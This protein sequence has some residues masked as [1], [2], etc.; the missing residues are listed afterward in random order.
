MDWLWLWLVVALLAAIGEVLTTGLYFAPFAVAAVLVAFFTAAFGAVI[1]PAAELAVDAALFAALSFL[2][3][4]VLRPI[5][6]HAL[7]WD[8]E[9]LEGPAPNHYL[10]DK[11]AVVTVPVDAQHGQIRVGQG[12]FWSARAFDPNDHFAA[13]AA[14]EI[15][16]VDGVN[17]LVGPVIEPA[18]EAPVMEEGLS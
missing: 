12:E 18:P 1:S 9:E 6:R 5:A 3:V 14:V 17:A 8:E 13:G 16:L 4:V 15:V 7:G 2:G 11:Q 10:M